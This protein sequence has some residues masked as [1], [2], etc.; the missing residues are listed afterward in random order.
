[1]L[2]HA[3]LCHDMRSRNADVAFLV[4]LKMS[5]NEALAKEDLPGGWR[6]WGWAIAAGLL[7]P[8]VTALSVRPNVRL[9]FSTSEA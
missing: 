7:M 4:H 9:Q 3:L 5:P 6:E 8:P 2:S 1:M